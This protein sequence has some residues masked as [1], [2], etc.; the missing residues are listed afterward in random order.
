MQLQQ[1]RKSI[2]INITQIYHWPTL[3]TVLMAEKALRDAK[4]PLSI[5]ELKR[6]LPTKI[7]DQTLRVILFYFEDKGFIII[8]DKGISWIK[9]DDPKFLKMIKKSKG[10]EL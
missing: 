3:K 7:M 5:E 4:E 8:G 1:E 6:R 9:N 2:N 10:I